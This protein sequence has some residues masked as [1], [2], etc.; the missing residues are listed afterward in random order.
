MKKP[1]H[2]GK[3][4]YFSGIE[5]LFVTAGITQQTLNPHIYSLNQVFWHE[6]LYM[7]NDKYIYFSNKY[8]YSNCLMKWIPLY[9]KIAVLCFPSFSLPQG[10]IADRAKL[11]Y[12]TIFV[13]LF[14]R[15]IY[16]IVD[17]T[18]HPLLRGF[19][20]DFRD[21]PGEADEVYQGKGGLC[22]QGESRE[23]YPGRILHFAR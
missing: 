2:C 5:V 9:F 3:P 11:L 4:H 15:Q 20:N 8:Q 21:L 13:R 23:E 7:Q 1:V 19:R 18:L 12:S 16:E 17:S 10:C 22:R 6:E 14:F